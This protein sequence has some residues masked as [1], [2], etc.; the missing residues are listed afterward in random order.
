MGNTLVAIETPTKNV[1]DAGE[2]AQELAEQTCNISLV[3]DGIRSVAEQLKF[4]ALN[5]AIEAARVGDAGRS[6]AVVTD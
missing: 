2:G 3:L 4:L 5:A 6:S 1:M